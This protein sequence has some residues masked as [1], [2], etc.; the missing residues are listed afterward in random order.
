ML[1][2]EIVVGIVCVPLFALG[3]MAVFMPAK[4]S[5]SVHMS[6]IGAAG[7]NEIRG[8]FGGFFLA[9]V[10]MIATGLASGETVWFLAVAVLM[11]AAAASRVGWIVVDGVKAVVPPLMIELV[12][13]GVMVGAHFAL[14]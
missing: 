8:V 5:E 11:G 7:L 12:I 4:M 10:A 2:M 6:P 13:G 9:C 3:V 1:A 14:N